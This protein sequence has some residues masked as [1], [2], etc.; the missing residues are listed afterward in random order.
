MPKL[1]NLIK[2][3]ACDMM[4]V[5]A[6]WDVVNFGI[7]AIGPNHLLQQAVQMQKTTDTAKTDSR[8]QLET[9]LRT[10]NGILESHL[11]Q[12]IPAKSIGS[13]Q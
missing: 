1:I 12:D 8:S 11:K 3:S 6:G 2:I 9:E 10:P 4:Y 13:I 7:S 5:S